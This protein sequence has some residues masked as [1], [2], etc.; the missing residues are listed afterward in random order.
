MDHPSTSKQ[1]AV[2]QF[3]QVIERNEFGETKSLTK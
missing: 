3:R 2:L 1:H